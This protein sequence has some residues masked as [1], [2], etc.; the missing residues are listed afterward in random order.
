L[1]MRC[2]IYEYSMKMKTRIKIRMKMRIR[3]TLGWIR[4]IGASTR[5]ILRRIMRTYK[6][7]LK[8]P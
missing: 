1:Q 2:E 8:R 3:K 6:N 7:L 4:I 5:S